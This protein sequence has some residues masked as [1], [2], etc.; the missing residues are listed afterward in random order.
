MTTSPER[1]KIANHPHIFYQKNSQKSDL[2]DEAM[3]KTTLI[4]QAELL[5]NKGHWLCITAVRSDHHNDGPNGHAGGR[6]FDCWPLVSNAPKNADG[7]FNY[8]PQDSHEMRQFLMDAAASPYNFQI[9][10]GG[11][12]DDSSNQIAAGKTEFDDSSADHIHI[13]V[14][15]G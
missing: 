15:D 8:V 3:T 10:L 14:I 4:A 2:L 5:L 6:A 13:G 11:C 9:G 1:E 7:S 12:A